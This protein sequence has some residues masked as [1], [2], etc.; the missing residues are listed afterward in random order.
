M[1]P[2]VHSSVRWLLLILP[3]LLLLLPS[4]EAVPELPYD[5]AP[6]PPDHAPPQDQSTSP[7]QLAQREWIGDAHLLV[8]LIQFPDYPADSNHDVAYYEELLFEHDN[9]SMWDFFNENSYGQFNISGT[10][11]PQWLNASEN[12]SYYGEYEFQNSESE[13][14]AQTLVREAVALAQPFVNYSHFDRDNDG[15]L[16]HL[17]M[18]HSGPTDESN[19]GGGPAGDDAI[20]SHRW[21][22]SAEYRNGTRISGYA[23]QGEGTPMG[24]F[25]HEFA[26][27]LGLPDLYDTD[28]S[29]SGIG[30]WGMMS[31][32][33]WLNGGD[34]PAQLCAW[35][36][37]FLGWVEPALPLAGEGEY[38][39]SRV[40]DNASIMKIPIDGLGGREYFL[41]E[42]RQNVGYD[43]YLP[44]HGLLI[45]HIDED[46]SQSNDAHRR[47]HLEEADNNNN[48]KQSSDSWA[49]TTSGFTNISS[50]NSD[51]YDSAETHIGVINIS[52]SGNMMTF[53]LQL[54][55]DLAII[56]AGPAWAEV[57]QPTVLEVVVENT[58]FEHLNATLVLEGTVERT[59]EIPWLPP[60][61]SWEWSEAWTP[62]A[63]GD[64]ALEAE[65]LVDD[66]ESDNNALSH[67]F[68]TTVVITFE[69]F[70][71]GL[72]WP[73]ANDS[74]WNTT[75]TRSYGGEIALW[76]GAGTAYNDDMDD[77]LLLPPLEL[78]TFDSAWLNFAH[79][80]RT[81]ANYDGGVV[82][83]SI[84]G[85]NWSLLEP[86]GGYPG[87]ASAANG[88]A[89]T[90]GSGG[91]VEASF[92]LTG[93]ESV[94]LRLRFASDFGSVDEG[95][96][97]DNLLLHGRPH[98]G[99]A[100]P[101]QVTFLLLP[102]SAG[103]TTVPFTNTGVFD[104]NYT[105]LL[106][107]PAG[108]NSS[109]P[110]NTSATAGETGG[111]TLELQ[112]PEQVLAGNYSGWL[113]ITSQADDNSS[114]SV[115][116]H[117][118][119]PEVHLLSVESLEPASGLPGENI[120]FTLT[121]HNSGNVP[122]MV[123]V[124]ISAGNWSVAA[125]VNITVNAYSTLEFN[126]TI[127]V[128]EVLADSLLLTTL[129][130]VAE[131]AN[132]TGEL[133]VTVEQ[134]HQPELELALPP[135]FRPGETRDMTLTLYNH[136]NGPAS[137]ALSLIAPSNWTLGQWNTTPVLAPWS[138]T[139]LAV[140]LTAPEG[141]VVAGAGV[142]EVTLQSDSESTSANGTPLLNQT[143]RL[144]VLV[145]GDS[146]LPQQ[147]ATATATI[148]NRGDGLVHITLEASSDWEY[149]LAQS[150]IWLAAGAEQDVQLR[151]TVPEHTLA[152]TLADFM[153]NAS[154]SVSS[155]EATGVIEALQYSGARFSG[156]WE[157]LVIDGQP[158]SHTLSL[159]SESNGLQSLV[160]ELEGD[161]TWEWSV[162]PSTDELA[163]W[164]S[165]P[166]QLLF[167][168]PYGTSGGTIG[169][170]TLRCWYGVELLA[171]QQFD[172]T[173]LPEEFYTLQA[174]PFVAVAPGDSVELPVEAWN[175]GNVPQAAKVVAVVPGGWQP[176]PVEFPLTP[177]ERQVQQLTLFVPAGV[178]PGIRTIELQLLSSDGELLASTEMQVSVVGEETSLP[179]FAIFVFTGVL[180]VVGF[181]GAWIWRLAGT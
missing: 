180:A 56:R 21:A 44:G 85:E 19:G 109:V 57:H 124:N 163:A 72:T 146:V 154:D 52:I 9:G 170:A 77:V 152:G 107:L 49:N 122:E 88:S 33:S 29:S 76:C 144:R 37:I 18:V 162:L 116:L 111:F 34:T 60:G 10:I 172:A 46:G 130:M 164:D 131:E 90:G 156:A 80:Y 95:W 6:P 39:I 178:E 102:D 173:I 166:V 71:N 48:P 35:S 181:V 55:S 45:W 53:E 42:N 65:L 13:G 121:L 120:T 75:D 113:N 50:P 27:D 158:G 1:P 106:E 68:S 7:P 93:F 4:A 97:I 104:D 110:A 99:V 167:N 43:T 148:R 58:G 92:N 145:E 11:V 134:R 91:W 127:T 136:G 63:W 112:L 133:S 108:W 119:V 165:R 174:E 79:W 89:F 62:D 177:R 153:V 139:V 179:A 128:P 26:H 41:L 70:E 67:S 140:Q 155:D 83:Y 40:E 126:V 66:D 20:W 118:E 23:M 105:I 160:L 123:A 176:L 84:D 24:V 54:P 81:E 25:G 169:S 141:E 36:K 5:L 138:S 78:G 147:N 64:Y 175:Y 82:E 159:V 12:M 73:V 115:R 151:V 142:I 149:E 38:N 161:P 129:R 32:G 132:A 87:S 157:A 171:E 150:T 86:E 16:D 96:F 117:I 168:P 143:Y 17:I 94:Q 59:V 8:I 3:L 69:E 22:I 125:P 30:H 137:M 101:P 98:F 74:L 28:Y 51:D 2:S 15:D 14:N 114:A 103:N 135:E 31:G 61:G 100:A 47:V